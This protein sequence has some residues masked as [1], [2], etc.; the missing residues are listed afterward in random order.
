MKRLPVRRR[1]FRHD[2]FVVIGWIV[3]AARNPER[4]HAR[5]LERPLRAARRITSPDGRGPPGEGRHPA[6]C[7]PRFRQRLAFP[8]LRLAEPSWVDDPGFE[9]AHHVSAL[10]G[11]DVPVP[12]EQ[13]RR[14]TDATLSEPLDRARPLWHLYLVPRLTDGRLGVT[15]KMH[16]ALVDGKSAVE[17]ALLLFDLSPDAEPEPEDEWY[18]A[19]P[20]NAARR[21]LDAFASNGCRTVARGARHDPHGGPTRREGGLP[22]AERIAARTGLPGPR[23]AGRSAAGVWPGVCT[24]RGLPG[25]SSTA[26]SSS[27]SAPSTFGGLP[28]PSRMR[29]MARRRKVGPPQ[30]AQSAAA[31]VALLR[32]RACAASR[33]RRNGSAPARRHP[34]AAARCRCGPRRSASARAPATSAGLPADL[35]PGRPRASCANPAPRRRPRSG[36]RR[37]RRRTSSPS[38]SPRPYTPG[39]ISTGPFTDRTLR[40][41]GAIAS[42]EPA[43]RAAALR[44]RPCSSSDGST[45]S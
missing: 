7:I 13:F 6:G 3:P 9:V 44:P 33:R 10:T 2:A 5:C 45:S 17:L 36:G 38:P 31:R 29:C 11:A 16:H 37:P 8:P 25:T 4:T 32:R 35:A 42:S 39:T 15:F 34:A 21:A 23:T 22:R 40:S 41:A 26:P 18:P 12:L 19:P 1:T 14:L 43:P 28:A 20:P 24:T 27:V 30:V